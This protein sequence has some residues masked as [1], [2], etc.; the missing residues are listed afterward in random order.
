MDMH[1]EHEGLVR[2]EWAI[3]GSRGSAASGSMA[4]APGREP[5]RAW[6]ATRAW[7]GTLSHALSASL[8]TALLL[9]C[10]PVA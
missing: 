9:A 3:R 7:A 4:P 10:I 1:R 8:V 6:R 5:W 2:R